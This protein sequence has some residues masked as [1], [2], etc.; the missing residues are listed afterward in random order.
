MAP[1]DDSLLKTKKN[2]V[3]LYKSQIFIQ[4]MFDHMYG[5][6]DFVKATDWS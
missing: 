5:Y 2:L 1:I 4:T 3:G 6:E